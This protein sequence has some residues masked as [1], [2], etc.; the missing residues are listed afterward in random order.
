METAHRPTSRTIGRLH[1]KEQPRPRLPLPLQ[2]KW[3]LNYRLKE[4]AEAPAAPPP[5]AAVAAPPPPKERSY[6]GRVF[7]GVAVIAVGVLGLFDEVIAGFHPDLH[8][9]VALALGVIGLGVVVGAWFGRPAGLV[10]LGIVL[11]PVLLLSRLAEAGGVNIISMEFTSVGNVQH[12]PGSVEDIRESY[13]LG[14]G[15]LTIDLREVDFAGH[16]VAMATEVGIGEVV[17]R[18]PEGVSADVS[19]HV[20]MGTLQVGDWDRGGIGVEADLRLEGS[21][22]TLVL[23]SEVGI[24]EIEVRAWRGTTVRHPG[25]PMM[26]PVDD[27]YRIPARGRSSRRLHAGR[28]FA[29]ARPRGTVSQKRQ[30][31]A[32][33]GRSRRR[34]GDRPAESEPA[35]HQPGGQRARH[36]VRRLLGGVQSEFNVLNPLF[37][38]PPAYTRHSSQQWD[39][40][41]GGGAMKRHPFNLFSLTFG[42]FLILLAAWTTW[43]AFPVRDGS[44]T[45]PACCSP[46]WRY[47]PVRR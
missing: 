44:S 27:E 37:K 34:A 46:R 47:W 19:G 13:E 4:R 16:T 43:I 12:R 15:G 10:T 40:D 8:H 38:R 33:H 25:F 26:K 17:V 45:P 9:Y 14:V 5:P 39:P 6:L 11:I 23:D 32:D 21:A 42:I 31:R 22:G 29:S 18:L 7:A 20:G 35:D 41:R 36:P 1:L 3:R 24:G 2:P 28:R 30:A